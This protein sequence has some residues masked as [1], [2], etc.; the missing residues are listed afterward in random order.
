MTDPHPRH[1][2]KLTRRWCSVFTMHY[3]WRCSMS[4]ILDCIILGMLSGLRIFSLLNVNVKTDSGTDGCSSS[5][6]RHGRWAVSASQTR[7]HFPLHSSCKSKLADFFCLH[8]FLSPSHLLNLTVSWVSASRS[9]I[10]YLEYI[11]NP[12][13]LRT[14]YLIFHCYSVETLL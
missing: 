3:I 8:I 12:C 7:I 1:R 6:L 10:N 11:Q 5:L 2:H 13:V 14:W 4:V 9:L